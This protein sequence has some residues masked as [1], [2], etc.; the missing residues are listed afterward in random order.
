MSVSCVGTCSHCGRRRFW[1]SDTLSIQLDDGRL[2]CLPHPAEEGVCKQEHG[3]TLGQ[4][5]DRGRLFRETF[6]VCR[7]C[8]KEGETIEKETAKDWS[9]TFSVREAMKWGWGSAAVVVPVLIWLRWWEAAA[10]VGVVLLAS[11]AIAWHE[12]RKLAKASGEPV[13]PRPDAPGAFPV[14]W[15]ARGCDPDTVVGRPLPPEAGNRRATG[16]CCDRPDWVEAFT[17]KDED[18]V[19]C[20]ACRRGVMVVSDHAIH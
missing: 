5:S 16:P 11:P 20:P 3:L 8:G 7:N 2:K 15:P 9:P 14:P 18:R 4:A 19:P 12:N 6:F 10:S 17:A 13:L 1:L